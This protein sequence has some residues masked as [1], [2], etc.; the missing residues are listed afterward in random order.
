M[1]DLATVSS[2]MMK[3]EE[4]YA[5]DLPNM[6]SLSGEIHNWYTKWKSEEKIKVQIHFHELS[7]EH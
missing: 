2:V 5:I 7:P 3:V 1:E 4:L 6:S